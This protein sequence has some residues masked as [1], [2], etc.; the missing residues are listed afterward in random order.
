MPP[1]QGQRLSQLLAI[2]QDDALS[3]QE[4]AELLSLMQ[5]Y[6]NI[7]LR[8][9]KALAEAVKRGLRTALEPLSKANE[10]NFVF[11]PTVI[12]LN[13]NNLISVTVRRNWVKAGWHP[14]PTFSALRQRAL[15]VPLA[16][17]RRQ[18]M[19]SHYLLN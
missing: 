4:Q 18:A 3:E 19:A 16:S 15:P 8:Q 9:S 7:W 1:H 5:N 13:L 11:K 2:Q 10:K 14:L 17:V 6:Q 12:A